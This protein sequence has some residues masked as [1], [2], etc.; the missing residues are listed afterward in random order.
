MQLQIGFGKMAGVS[1]I[2]VGCCSGQPVRARPV[3]LS[4]EPIAASIGTFATWMP[5]GMRSLAIL[6]ASPDFA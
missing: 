3:F 6:W 2:V 1:Q 4:L 5:F